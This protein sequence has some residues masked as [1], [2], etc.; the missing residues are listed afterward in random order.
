MNAPRKSN[1]HQCGYLCGVDVWVDE[2]ERIVHIAPDPER[3]PFDAQVMNRCHRFAV[4]KD[5]ID[6]PERVNYPLK[7]TGRRGSGQWQR[8][9]WDAALEGIAT[10]LQRLKSAHGPE[11]LASCISAPHMIYWPLHRFLNLWGTPNNIGI[12]ISC[13][14]PRIWVNS[15]T[16]GWP[17]EDEIVP[18]VTRCVMA[19]GVNPAES[20]NSLFWK[21]LKDFTGTDGLLVVVDPR[22]TRTA[23]LADHW[24][25]I[26]PGTDG[27]LVLGM[28]NVLI[29]E[30]LVDRPFV[31]EWCTGFES[32]RQ[33]AQAYSLERV[34]EITDI[35][36]ETIART[37]R[38]LAASKPAAIITGLGIDMCGANCTHTLRAIAILRA[39]TGN[40]DIPGA[41]CLNEGPDFVPEVEM[42][43]SRLFSTRQRN[44]KLGKGLFPLQRYS[45]YER[46]TTFTSQHG[47]VLPARYL[48]SAHPHLAWQAMITRRPYPIRALITMASNPL[49]CQANTSMVY[50]AL[51][52]LD[53]LVCLEQF[54]TPTAMQADYVLPMA[55]SL[56]KSMVQTNG[57]VANLAYGGG[58]AIRPLYER[59]TGFDFWSELGRRCGQAMHWPWTSLE[60]ALDSMFLPCGHS[61]ADICRTGGYAPAP[62][63]RKYLKKGF[64]TPSQK[65]ELASSLLKSLG[66]DPLPDFTEA[67]ADDPAYPLRLM[68]GVR[69][70]PYY[71]SEFRQMRRLRKKFARPVAEMAPATADR[72]GLKQGDRIWI[73]TPQGRIQQTLRLADMRVD[74][75]SVEYG[76]WFPE[77]PPREPDLG[78]LWVSNANVLTTADTDA[79]DP[80][81]GQWNFRSL[82]CTV[83]PAGD[84]AS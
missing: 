5:L 18:G 52:E 70:Q 82:P 56:E 21:T 45:G 14:N 3:Y 69:K 15:L 39:V 10:E 22:R 24:L 12:G 62:R 28:L 49:L 40:V 2:H 65:I 4:L 48:T 63:Y 43:L 9:S 77:Q 33:R 81:L 38:L 59:R 60:D 8:V 76:W 44:K 27:A 47:N 42:D 11:T 61:W 25:K 7:R 30:K 20:D 36:A 35:P 26:R 72:L 37:A 67:R 46:L 1:C 73:E 55:G 79:C 57:G 58:A 34:S 68:T 17:L 84:Y 71:A 66:H 53:L 13:W 23:R 41:C 54:M 29:Q 51:K 64:A 6:H 19:F 83:Y 74:L 78:G 16:F 80:I 32:L 75:V 31:D 50:Q